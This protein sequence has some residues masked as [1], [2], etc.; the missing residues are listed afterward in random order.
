MS[1]APNDAVVVLGAGLAGLA[2]G[3][4]L[5]RAGRSVILL[6]AGEAVGGLS[7]TVS[8]DGFRYDLGGHR[9]LTDDVELEALVRQILGP[10]CLTVPRSSKILMGG[11]YFDYPLRP[12]NAFFGFGPVTSARILFDYARERLWPTAR[13]P[14]N[15]EDWVVRHFGRA[16]FDI[17]FRDYSEKVWGLD[18]RRIDM[19]WVAQRIQGL[20]LGEAIA[21]ALPIRL[22]GRRE[23]DA[24]RQGNLRG[25]TRSGAERSR[26]LQRDLPTLTSRFLYPRLGIG[27]I[28]DGLAARIR[29]RN[30]I[31]TSTRVL[32][33]HHACGRVEG[34]DVLERSERRLLRGAQ[35]V[36]TIPLP[37]LVAALN[38]RPPAPVLAAASRL[39]S[40]DLLTV[41]VM[42]RGPRVTQHT[43]IYLPDKSVPFGR[44]HEPTN[45][46]P[47]MAPPGHTLLVI[48]YFCFRGDVLWSRDDADIAQETVAHLV[49]LGLVEEG[50]V[51]GHEVQRIANAYPLFEVGYDEHCRTINDYLCGFANLHT[52]GRN[53]MFRYFNMDRAML[54][55]RDGARAI[56]ARRSDDEALPAMQLT[57]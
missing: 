16:M 53:G 6:E 30:A 37:A 38:P 55:G 39:G 2:A 48:E 35:F 45:W 33:V 36:S 14:V 11:R 13:P 34:V 40:R 20:S 19:R 44:I 8:R 27:Q 54:A 28:A 49:D 4:E 57:A 32:K 10:D 52:A 24:Q 17:Y 43:W 26:E 15:L 7:R 42:L 22:P 1:K 9:F 41:A 5:T 18:C 23:V 25:G 3:D 31:R 50:R 46:S 47:D 56:L 21:R 51:V 12:L 29:Q